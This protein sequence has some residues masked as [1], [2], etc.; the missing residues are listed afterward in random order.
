MTAHCPLC[1][2][3]KSLVTVQNFIGQLFFPARFSMDETINTMLN[4]NTI[5]KL[6]WIVLVLTLATYYIQMYVHSGSRD[7]LITHV[8]NCF[9]FPAVRKFIHEYGILFQY[10]I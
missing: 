1:S 9:V 2:C 5:F 7:F 3:A 6:I 10:Y 8:T 4:F